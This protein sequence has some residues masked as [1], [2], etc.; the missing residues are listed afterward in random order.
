M[1]CRVSPRSIAAA[2]VLASQ[3]SLSACSTSIT[4]IPVDERG[5]TITGAEVR[6]NGILRGMGLTRVTVANE[7]IHQVVITAGPNYFPA[8]IAVEEES[9]PTMRVPLSSDRAAADTVPSAEAKVRANEFVTIG[10]APGYEQGAD[11]WRIIVDSVSSAQYQPALLDERSG[12]LATEWKETR[13]PVAGHDTP[14]VVRRRIVGNLVS[15]QPL[16]YRLKL[17]VER[18]DIMHPAFSAWN[19]VFPEDSELMLQLVSRAQ[20]SSGV[21]SAGNTGASFFP[22]NRLR[23]VSFPVVAQPSGGSGSRGGYL[24]GNVPSFGGPAY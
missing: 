5:E 18:K 21:T 2:L 11:W 23:P 4:V 9:E 3:L 24:E 16:R 12:Y 6:V 10:I 7:E 20:L 14:T 13:Y 17:Q 19:R 15:G 22:S 1:R 8:T